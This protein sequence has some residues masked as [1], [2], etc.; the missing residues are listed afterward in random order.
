MLMMVPT[1]QA[2][3]VRE[4]PVSRAGEIVTIGKDEVINRDFYVT[5]GKTVE[6]LGLVNG[7]IYAF[8]GQIVVNGIV[9][10][11]VI[12][13]G[14]QVRIAGNVDQNVRVAGG[15]VTLSGEVGRNVTMAGGT[16]DIAENATVGGGLMVA[17]GNVNLLGSVNGD[18]LAAGGNV[19]IGGTVGGDVTAYVG[20]L[21]V[22]AAAKIDGGL[23]YYSKD[24]A[25]ID[26]EAVIAGETKME[27]V[28]MET[29]WKPEQ[30]KAELKQAWQS[31][32]MGFRVMGLIGTGIV[33]LILVSLFP[34]W[35][36]KV[37]EKIAD[38][39]GMSIG[40]GLLMLL[41]APMVFVFMLITVVGI[42]LG[43][44]TLVSVAVIGYVAQVVV[45]YWIGTRIA[46]QFGWKLQPAWSFLLGLVIMFA[47]SWI[48]ILGPLAKM[49]AMILG[50]GAIL[51]T[52]VELYKKLSK[53]KVI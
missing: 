51:L 45:D 35:N 20:N 25:K 34:Y 37:A 14:G 11:D 1:V 52:E 5:A 43:L 23:L 22:G 40:I 7:D 33:G 36:Q 31:V 8:G 27:P 6:V 29:N 42:P 2:Q 24:L 28:E 44:L 15:Q 47:V 41:L 13:A 46:R 17:G 12:A 53:D 48:P 3:E 26:S 10:G 30:T 4:T 16:L 9:N 32:R 50:S 18:V 39:P 38:K 49:L 19:D 21:R